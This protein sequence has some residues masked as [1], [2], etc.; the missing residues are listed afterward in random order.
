MKH[1]PAA[2]GGTPPQMRREESLNPQRFGRQ[3]FLPVSLEVDALGRLD[4]LLF[5]D[6]FLGE[7]R[8]ARFDCGGSGS[9]RSVFACSSESARAKRA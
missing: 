6:R 8:E 3:V 4:L 9:L 7:A 5:P 2:S 1:H